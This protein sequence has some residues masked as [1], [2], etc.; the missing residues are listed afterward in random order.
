MAK[1][2]TKKSGKN[3]APLPFE[4]QIWD[5]ACVLWGSIPAADY[6]K[7]I[8][9]LIFLR[10]VSAR[11]EE[12]YQKLLSEGEGDENERDCYESENVFW[13][14]QVSRWKH[15][16]EQAH[17]PEIGMV[18]DQAMLAIEKE[19]AAL[20]GVLPKIYAS[21]DLDKRVLG[22]VVD[23]F[24]NMDMSNA[25][26]SC[27]LLGRTYEYCIA[28]FAAYE[29]INGGEFYTPES[30][31]KTLVAILKPFSNCRVYDP[32]CG[33]GGMFV[34]SAKFI[35]AHSGKRGDISIFGQES[36]PDTWKMAKINM[37]IRG[38]C[39]D[40]GAHHADTFHNDLHKKHKADFIIA[41][42]PFNLS[43]WG[44]EQLLQ[45]VRWKYGTP[46][47]SN[48]N[49]AWIQHMLHHLAPKGRI[50][51][52][53]ANS[54]VGNK[55]DEEYRIRRA[56]IEDGLFDCVVSLPAQMFYTTKI[57]VSLLFLSNK[58]WRDS[59]DVLFIDARR[60]GT[61]ENRTQRVFSDDE[62]SQISQI[63]DSFF[64]KSGE[65]VK[66][67][68]YASA[69]IEEIRKKD[70]NLTPSKYIAG[71]DDVETLDWYKGL[72]FA[73]HYRELCRKEKLYISLQT[74]LISH[75]I[76]DAALY[77]TDEV[78]E[79]KKLQIATKNAFAVLSECAEFW[80]R[81]VFKRWFVDFNFPNE[82]GRPYVQNGGALRV[83]DEGDLIPK[84]W[85]V[86]EMG[87]FMQ[88]RSARVGT[89]LQIPEYSATNRG[90]FPRSVKFN[91]ILSANT[92]K[93]KIIHKG[94]MIFGMSRDILNF[95]VMRE[96]VGSV[97]P[98]YH[99]YSID[100][101]IY[102]SEFLEIFM[103]LCPDSFASLIKPGAREGQVLD[104]DELQVKT[105]LVPPIE[106]QDK[107]VTM[108]N[109]YLGVYTG[110]KTL[111]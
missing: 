42:P 73:K 92:S 38:I 7:V 103:R 97:S 101:K 58:D 33:S 95:G 82:D 31:V 89:A 23:I 11:F 86:C 56:M 49:Y 81:R 14:P 17:T 79:L 13:V 72:S 1:K 93:N 9:G 34:Q 36:N 77:S 90:I 15:I 16:A 2:A 111:S 54:A 27:D 25:A 59:T 109:R 45:D 22:D 100:S 71:R 105:V 5:A 80:M 19:N 62:I 18:L 108:A 70:Y 29:G 52:V 21:P 61:M 46:P 66:G 10:Y 12:L 48:A 30:V 50:G 35:E 84:N 74:R 24:T 51:L 57:K 65:T 47:A 4:E 60:M 6:R 85:E 106:L 40:F 76:K 75:Y 107:Y 8:I 91:K 94:D 88:P 28:K 53:I 67:D 96:E 55:T 3:A 39:A 37:A 87:I 99:V 102:N 43:G 63:V 41:N 83:N 69:S 78:N 104:Q 20:K 98:A 110:L 26:Q 64:N 32:C 68:F 44:Q